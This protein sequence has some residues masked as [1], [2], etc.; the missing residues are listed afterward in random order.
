MSGFTGNP[1]TRR[2]A[3]WQIAAG[4][5]GFL[6]GF[7]FAFAEQ[8][9]RAGAIRVE[10]QPTGSVIWQI[11]TQQTHHS[12]IYCEIP[13]C[14]RDSRYFVYERRNPA[15]TVNRTEFVAVELGTWEERVVDTATGI[16]GCL[17]TREGVL[18]YVKQIGETQYLMRADLPDGKPEQVVA[19]TGGPWLGNLGTLSADGRYYARIKRLNDQWNLFG[20]VL[21][22]V[23]TGE[24]TLIDQDPYIFNAHPQFEPSKS[25]YLMIQHNRGGQFN[26]DGTRIRLTGPEGATL[27]LLSIP[28]GKRTE[29]QVG[30]PYTPPV[31]GHEAWIGDTEEIL[32]TVS[33]RDDY[34]PDK[35]GNLVAVRPGGPARVIGGKGYR[36]GHV[37]V[38]RCGR[39]FA[40]DDCQGTV[41]I[42]I[43]SIR[44]GKMAVVCESKTTMTSAQNTHAH[45]YL[46]PDLKWVVFNSTRSGFPHVHVASVPDGMVAA[47]DA[48]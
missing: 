43:G 20:V 11:T 26:P 32:L 28:Q 13:Y 22:D 25:H 27:Y 44:T 42:V 10:E 4:T 21:I 8:R 36:F 9:R 30:T 24:Q 15:L 45:P 34:A 35:K 17:V 39:Y 5:F 12:N 7:P 6:S 38:S 46:T 18:Y 23:R 14:S 40:C 48:G 31:T 47:L 3:I 37:H 29:L 33:A 19:L 2:T 1:I 41:K 16:G